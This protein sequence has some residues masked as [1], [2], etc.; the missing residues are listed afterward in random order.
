MPESSIDFTDDMVEPDHDS[1]LPQALE[2]A[3]HF[4][5]PVAES[6]EADEKVN[7]DMLFLYSSEF[8]DLFSG[9]AETRIN[10]L[11]AFT[12]QAY[13]D[14]GILINLRV[15]G[16]VELEGI[17]NN[18]TV[19]TLLT[20]ARTSDSDIG[21]GDVAALRNQTGGDLVAVLTTSTSNFSSNGTCLL[22][23]SPSPRD[24]ST[25]RMPS[26]A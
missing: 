9:S 13:D 18:A 4:H 26:S 1:D 5:S 17:E 20:G 15:A 23:T 2:T 11:I 14:T 10:Q 22:Y 21:F 3:A 7:I 6:D 25:S 8:D 19:G 12:N 16:A 24:L